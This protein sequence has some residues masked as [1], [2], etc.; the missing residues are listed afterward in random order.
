MMMDYPRTNL[1]LSELWRAI[2]QT[3]EASRTQESA[4]SKHMATW[5]SHSALDTSQVRREMPYDL[6]KMGG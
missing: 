2:S 4:R 6:E 1:I 5:K 3:G